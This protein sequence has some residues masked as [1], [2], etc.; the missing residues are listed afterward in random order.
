MEQASERAELGSV[1]VGIERRQWRRGTTAVSTASLL[2][3]RSLA[4]RFA[5]EPDA[6]SCEVALPIARH[7]YLGEFTYILDIKSNMEM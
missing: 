2:L 5:G 1:R 4:R 6:L 3:A 7:I